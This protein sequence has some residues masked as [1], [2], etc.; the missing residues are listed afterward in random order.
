MKK[1]HRYIF[2]EV[3]TYFLLCLF[4]LTFVLLLNRIFQLTDLVVGKGVPFGLL[5]RLLLTL[6][7]VLLLAALPAAALIACILAFS[8]LSN[9]SESIAMTATG[10]SLYSQLVPVG[11][12]GCMAAVASAFLMLYG[13]SWSQRVTEAIT[14]EIFQT[15][16]AAF[17]I[18]EQVFNDTFDGVVLYV[19]K[20]E[21]RDR[22]MR[23]ILIS[24]SREPENTQVIFAEEGMLVSDAASRRLVLHLSQ[25][26][27]HK[28]GSEPGKKTGQAPQPAPPSAR[29]N[30]YQV[31][32]FSTYDLNMDLTQT[33]R[34][35]RAFRT[36]LRA[37]PVATLRKQLEALEPGTAKHNAVLVELHKKFATPLACLILALLGAPLGVQNRRSGRHGGFA[38]SLAVLLVYY[39][40]ATFSE[41]MG[42]SGVLPPSLAAWGPNALLLGLALWAIRR[43]VRRGAV[44]L[45]GLL[46]RALEKVPLPRRLQPRTAA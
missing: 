31:L 13:L 14:A 30:P 35:T 10:M 9:D 46:D 22:K 44:D 17:E 12:L 5:S 45:F 11:V 40:L 36:S 24:D 28:F 38:L 16:A 23:G 27:L 19:R 29:E 25:G 39:L 18:R 41:G 3:F 7:P 1:L 4:L 6:M 8:R 34:E 37:Q 2:G 15:R 33:L 20:I 21:G 32:R 43:V 42:E 26:T